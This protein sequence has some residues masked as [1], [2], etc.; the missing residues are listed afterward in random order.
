MIRSI[1]KL[2]IRDANIKEGFPLILKNSLEI[3]KE[4]MK[5][6]SKEIINKKNLKDIIIFLYK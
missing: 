6:E 2:K 1:A 3:L 5:V 4:K